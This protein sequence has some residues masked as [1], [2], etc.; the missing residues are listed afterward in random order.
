MR[1]ASKGPKRYSR[2]WSLS[3]SY[4]CATSRGCHGQDFSAKFTLFR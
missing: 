2:L 1:S 4:C 3:G